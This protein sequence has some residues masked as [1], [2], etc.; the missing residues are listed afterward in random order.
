MRQ[1]KEIIRKGREQMTL[2]KERKSERK[3]KV[4]EEHRE[5]VKFERFC[6]TS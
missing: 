5:E 4:K 6:Q 1:R 3:V 2:R